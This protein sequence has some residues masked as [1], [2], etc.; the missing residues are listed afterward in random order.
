MSVANPPDND[1]LGKAD[2]SRKLSANQANV[3]DKKKTKSKKLIGNIFSTNLKAFKN[4]LKKTDNSLNA[5]VSL[6]ISEK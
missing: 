6:K 5:D 2:K 4:E 1:K 3:S